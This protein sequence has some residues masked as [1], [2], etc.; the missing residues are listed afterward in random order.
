MAN[1]G[2][3]RRMQAYGV[4]FF[5]RLEACFLFFVSSSIIS[6]PESHLSSFAIL[7]VY[8]YFLD[9]VLPY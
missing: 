4:R 2:Y 3:G 9:I 7:P 1:Y 5:F 6:F 8:T